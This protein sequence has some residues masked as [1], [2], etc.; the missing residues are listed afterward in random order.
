MIP[1]LMSSLQG[2]LMTSA[3]GTAPGDLCVCAPTGCGK[4]LCYVVPIVSALMER[5]V[6]QVRV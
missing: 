5:V 1:A 6:C 4:T 2:P 3:N